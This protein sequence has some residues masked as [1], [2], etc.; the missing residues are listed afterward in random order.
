MKVESY[1]L[2]V[3]WGARKE[4]AGECAQRARRV[5]VS[6]VE[7]DP[8]FAHWFEQGASQNSALH[9]EIALTETSLEALF[10]KG[11]NRGDFSNRPIENLG[12]RVALWT[13]G[14]DGG[15][16]KLTIKCGCYARAPLVN[17]CVIGLPFS[18]AAAARLLQTER[19]AT[20]MKSSVLA[21]DPDWGVVMTRAYQS[22][23]PAPATLAPQV[24]W[25]LYLSDRRG[26]IPQLPEPCK[27]RQIDRVGSL[28]V[29]TY[30]RF[31]VNNDAH[32]ETAR[33]VSEALNRDGLLGPPS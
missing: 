18:G 25:M 24:G 9:N 8:I 23:L 6:L 29:T 11:A 12:F 3:Y 15:S 20:I 10:L 16:A 19:L 30:D 28:I 17:S 32:V 1:Y 4:S 21:W 31:T 14:E 26:K 5:L 2:A 22:T 27:V 33:H 13:G 7:C